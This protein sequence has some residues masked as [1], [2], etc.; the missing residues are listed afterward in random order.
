MPAGPTLPSIGPQQTG[1][2]LVAWDVI[3]QKEKW[4]AQG[5]G[6]IG[7][8]TVATA[9]NIVFQTLGN[10][11]LRALSADKGEVLW[12]VATGQTGGM[13][14]PITFQL[15]GKQYIAVAGGQGQGAG[16]GRGGPPAAATPACGACIAKTLRLHA[17]WQ[18]PESDTRSGDATGR[19][20]RPRSVKRGPKKG[21]DVS[22]PFFPGKKGE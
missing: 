14:P 16:G 19:T 22:F 13:G 11:H 7:G 5:G 17:R 15:D 6:S 21:P 9:S 4:R 1:S 20:R 2:W 12:D 18:R 10:G 3:T 8:G